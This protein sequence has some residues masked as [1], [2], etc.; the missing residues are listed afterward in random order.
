MALNRVVNKATLF[1]NLNL[2][3]FDIYSS[4]LLEF[5]LEINKST[6]NFFTSLIFILSLESLL[7]FIYIHTKFLFELSLLL[8][9]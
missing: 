8:E 1:D 9:N 4:Y 3:N 5:I 7:G 6:P 2:E